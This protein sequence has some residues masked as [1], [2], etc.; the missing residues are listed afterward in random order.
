MYYSKSVQSIPIP[1]SM[2]Q[3]ASQHEIIRI[4]LSSQIESRI[5][6]TRQNTAYVG[7]IPEAVTDEVM[8]RLLSSCGPVAKWKRVFDAANM[9]KSFGF[10]EFGSA[11]AMNRALNILNDLPLIGG[12][13]LMVKIDEATKSYL[14]RYTAALD[15][16]HVG[17]SS[18]EADLATITSC[19]EILKEK[20][21]YAAFEAMEKKLVELNKE[22]PEEGEAISGDELETNKKEESRNNV[23]AFIED[24]RRRASSP[25]PAK[26]DRSRK[27]SKDTDRV[28][29][30][31]EARWES[32]E[33]QIHQRYRRMKRDDQD[34]AQREKDEAEAAMKHF[35][36]L[37]DFSMM[38]SSLDNLL[39]LQIASGSHNGTANS[40]VP[41][42]YQNRELWKTR[43]AKD[44]QREVENDT[45]DERHEMEEEYRRG[46]GKSAYSTVGGID[47]DERLSK[48]ARLTALDL[49]ESKGKVKSLRDPHHGGKILLTHNS[50]NEEA[51][52]SRGFNK[53]EVADRLAALKKEK[54]SAL[55]KIIPSDPNDLF[56]WEVEWSFLDSQKLY[57]LIEKKVKGALEAVNNYSSSNAER[58]SKSLLRQI[59]QHATPQSIIDWI[60]EDAQLVS[61][62]RDIDAA[63]VFVAILWRYLVFE[64]EAK[65][66]NLQ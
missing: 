8:E 2:T 30:E 13:R 51:L 20:N 56:A 59:E 15:E 26:D 41:D 49:F 10:C 47:F 37:D 36:S 32:K 64:T 3:Q 42:F 29:R 19:I 4:S 55:I 17:I 62:R 63:Q 7:N 16:S 14:A 25:E 57:S 11:D 34:R 48:K 12:K 9:P 39:G 31:R 1:T 66:Y 58:I 28:L 53:D 21:F 60:L 61:S 27:P 45:R 65:S 23:D 43:R 52:L 44:S 54:I 33:Q 6:S 24:R 38:L 5:A 35:A 22:A 50:D 46:N 40:R 18:K